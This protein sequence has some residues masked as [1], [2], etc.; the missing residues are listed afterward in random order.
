MKPL[1]CRAFLD[2]YEKWMSQR[3]SY[4][5]TGLKISYRSAILEQIRKFE[6]YIEG[7]EDIYNPFPWSQIN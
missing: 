2:A 7:E 1:A 3:V 6:K 4:P 5:E